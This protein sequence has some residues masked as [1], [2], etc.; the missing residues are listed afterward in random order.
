ME[1]INHREKQLPNAFVFQP[2][3][4]EASRQGNVKAEP[5]REL[6][7]TTEERCFQTTDGCPAQLLNRSESKGRS[8]TPTMHRDTGAPRVR[9]NAKDFWH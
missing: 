4:G 2:T 5:D 8:P 7:G 9:M 6:S 3:Q 1:H